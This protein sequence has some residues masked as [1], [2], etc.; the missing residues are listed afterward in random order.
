[1]LIAAVRL[2]GVTAC[3]HVL[4]ASEAEQREGAGL[5]HLTG[6][7]NRTSLQL[8]F[9]ELV[10]RV[11]GEELLVLLPG[12]GLRDAVQLAERLRSAIAASRP[13]GL[14]VT[15]SFGVAQAHEDATLAETFDAADAA[16]YAAK[17]AG[18]DCVRVAGAVALADAA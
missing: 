1:M 17:T 5:D 11:G 10:Y 3:V 14:E 4:N 16:L 18:R 9:D 15:A 8:R 2:V 12:A 6:L 7:L 13:G